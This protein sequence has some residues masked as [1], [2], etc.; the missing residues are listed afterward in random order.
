MKGSNYNHRKKIMK[1]T[2]VK[3]TRSITDKKKVSDKPSSIKIKKREFFML[4]FF[5]F[6]LFFL[7]YR[8]GYIQFVKG[9][10]YQKR[11]YSN[12]TQKRLINP[13]RG[14]IYDRNGK[15]LAISASVDT[16]GVNPKELRDA[17]GGDETKLRS[18]ANDLGAML[19]MDSEIIMKKFQANSR[20]EF[21]KRKIDRDTGSQVRAYVS[22]AGLWSIYV[23]E[24]S[25]RYYP[26]G[27][28][29][30]HVLGFT[31]SDDQGL[32]GI[33]MVLESTLKGV[34]GKIMNEVDVLG[35]QIS[36]SKERYIDAI[37]G[38]D[39]YLTIDETI[40][41]LAEKAMD[42]AVLDYNLKR[43]ATCIVMNP[44][45][46]EILAM[47]SKPDFDPNNPDALPLGLLDEDWKGFD[48]AEDSEYL[49]Q[50]VFRNKAVMDTYEPGSVFKAITAAAALEENVV[51]LDTPEVC[52]PISLAG[53]TINCWRKGGHGA[54]DFL[55]AVYNSCNPV[56]V[57]TGM[58]LG[59]AKFYN[60]FRLFGF[61]ERTGIELQGEPSNEEYRNLQHKDP[62]EIDLAVSSFGQ[63]FQISPI[64][65]ITAYAAIA[66]GGNLLKPT[67][68]K[69]ISDSEGN[70]IKK[71]EPQV[72]RKV[73]SEQTAQTVREVLEGVV[74][75]GTGRNAYVSGYRIGG[76][77]GTSQTLQTD[78]EG[79]YVVSFMAIA[80]AN[81]P[82]VCVL[83]VLDHPQNEMHLRSGGILA[84]PVA[85]ALTEEILKYMQVEREYTEKD[86]Q[87]MAQEVYVPNVV[88]Y[89]LADAE[90]K[91]K[92]FGLEYEV[93][94][95]KTD[96]DA[97]IYNQT[98]KADFSIPQKS[99]VILY[100]DENQAEITVTMPDLKDRTVAEAIEVLERVGLNIRIHGSGVVQKQ[101]YPA[102]TQ[103]S[104]GQVV[105]ISFVEMIGD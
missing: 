42:Q 45:T 79:R 71:V 88:G 67:I 33:E 94:G 50:T 34:P 65:M 99:T 90:S 14:T 57:K 23:D 24:D 30:S 89:S 12:Q 52:K 21:I 64:Q 16:V 75:E 11:A 9:E 15:G 41:Y 103:L 25:K 48:D 17:V 72:I 10:E 37:D 38:Y 19:G 104:K 95:E 96:P 76:K 87:E 82:E 101:E 69:Q 47:V 55:H 51:T 86:K 77:T 60:Y 43:G 26:K 84:A 3:N 81:K 97:I 68:I 22:N 85:G 54:E 63:R 58:D 91:L 93:E 35:R 105:E 7:I 62:K 80:P 98:P 39:V 78:S 8:L 83:V 20:F 2:T 44:N 1:K 70:I 102:G 59:I 66:N 73:I 46:G 13:K 4:L 5:T 49:W 100:T 56:F 53:H 18:I 29:A 6:C 61:T 92:A 27:N 31:G 36:F 28:L 40:Q 74:S 32:N